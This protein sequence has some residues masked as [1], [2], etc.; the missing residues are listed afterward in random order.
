[1]ASSS[2]TYLQA[3]ENTITGVAKGTATVTVSVGILSA[4]TGT[5]TNPV[6]ATGTVAVTVPTP[7]TSPITVTPSTLTIPVFETQQFSASAAGNNN[8]PAVTWSVLQSNGGTITTDGLYTAPSTPGTYTVVATSQAD[9]S[10]TAIVNVTVV[11]GAAITVTPSTA[12]VSVYGTQ[13]FVA[14]ASA[15]GATTPAVTWSVLQSDGGSVGTDGTYTAPSTPGTYTVVATSQA[16]PSQT[17]T[18]TVTVVAGS[19][20]FTIK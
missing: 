6:S 3:F 17:A 8:N 2:A 20:S 10:Q 7:T 9:P 12:T 13:R 5:I 15:K 1:V 18:A 11:H 16:D 19:T 4:T 14:S